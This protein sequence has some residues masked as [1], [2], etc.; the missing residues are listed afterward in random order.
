M[1]D[2]RTLRDLLPGAIC[3]A[4]AL[5]VVVPAGSD[6]F[7][8]TPRAAPMR[9][10]AS[11]TDP[12]TIL[13]SRAGLAS[14]PPPAATTDEKVVQVQMIGRKHVPLLRIV[15]HIRTR[16]GQP[17]DMELIEEDVRRLN[18][19]GLF[20]SV[21]T[22]TQRAAGG[23]IVIFEVVERPVLQY[24]KYVGNELVR[25]SVLAD[26]AGIKPGDAM[27]PFAVEEGRSKIETYYR[28][29]GF[30]NVRVTV[31]EG[32]EVDDQGAIYLINEGKKQRILWTR[33]VGNS[34]HI[35]TDARLRTQ[36]QSKP[37]FLWI[38]K[39]E[40]DRKEIEED[41]HRLKAYYASLGFLDARIG[42]DP[43]FDRDKSWLTL[44]FVIHE[45]P[46]YKI[47][48]V[49]FVGNERFADVE[50]AETTE[51]D[52]GMY[53][54]QTELQSD[55]TAIQ[56]K[57]GALGYVF[58]D[59]RPDTRYLGQDQPGM[60]DLVYE[61]REGDRY[62]VGRI[63]V[64]IRGQ[65][66]T[67]H[68][69]IRT[70]LDRLSLAPGDIVD[71]RE[72]RAS[73]RRLRA[74][75]LFLHEPHRGVEP[76]IVFSP[77]ELSEEETEIARRPGGPSRGR[78]PLTRGQSPDRASRDRTLVLTVN[79]DWSA[80]ADEIV[81][82]ERRDPR[83]WTRAAPDAWG[84]PGPRRGTETRNN[85]PRAADEGSTSP[86]ASRHESWRPLP[87]PVATP[88]EAEP[89]RHARLCPVAY[90]R[91]PAKRPRTTLV[92]AQSPDPG[93][94]VPNYAQGKPLPGIDSHLA[95]PRASMFPQPPA[96]VQGGT[97]VYG[98]P[99]ASA[100]PYG[101]PQINPAQPGEAPGM[102]TASEGPAFTPGVPPPQPGTPGQ[103][104]PFYAP[105]REDASV[106][107][108]L[109]PGGGILGGGDGVFSGQPPSAD[110]VDEA[111]R[112]LPL[113]AIAEESR[114][115][116]IMLGVGVTSDAGLV[117]SVVVDEQNFDLFRFPRSFEEIRNGKAWRG[118][119]QRFRAEAVP[120][121][122]VQRY[123]VSFTEPYLYVPFYGPTQVSLGLSGYFFNRIYLDWAEERLGG[124]VRTGYQFRPDL[125][126]NFTFRGEKVAIYNPSVD[127]GLVPELDEVLGDN[128]LFGFR[129]GIAHD[130]RDSA[131]LP[132]E[133][134]LIEFGFEQVIGSFEYPRGDID[135]RKYF[136]LRQRADGSGRHVLSVGASFGITGDDTPI[137]D[138]YFIGGFSTLRGFDFRGASPRSPT[139]VIVGGH[140]QLLG[141]I[142]YLFPITADDT[143]RGVVFCDAGTVETGYDISD[144][145]FRVAPGFGLRVTIPAM[146]PAPLA[147]D[148]AWP[149][150]KAD[151]DR[152][153]V[154][155]FFIGLR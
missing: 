74:S 66:V 14:P 72:L 48:D 130:T 89:A 37:G 38:I 129:V 34:P 68:T 53:F 133:G 105:P 75:G 30:S 84:M 65:D 12:A 10:P 56:E 63:D 28:S 128:E 8:Q 102:A 60:V 26:K 112:S 70:V 127:P 32:N 3:L 64:E 139:G 148:F 152:T 4:A 57:Y 106:W 113:Q 94:A 118:A 22:M 67:P 88:A 123:M 79:G 54:N 50:L 13:S 149:V 132:T 92:R 24:V 76:K 147:F 17:L 101:Q 103:P 138:H 81:G 55:V 86:R 150:A 44:T 25:K 82:R 134:H 18:R 99:S 154:F 58:A 16:A 109:M 98:T 115:G 78:R 125:T 85:P 42:C 145:N 111:L 131:F 136:T 52:S 108:R 1:A 126:A 114:T 104:G 35:A 142:Q 19:S 21:K 69:K 137:Y 9:P 11:A 15:P 5:A 146:G 135:V 29:H 61:I 62:R 71:I 51:L 90:D 153:E 119:G 124:T 45:G 100:S 121:T 80:E 144:E 6:S 143:L 140:T 40:V 43:H 47:R 91:P 33:F 96:A 77:P 97:S 110:P 20:V 95:T 141:S 122:E 93:R 73:E 120:G 39:G 41:K 36:I 27:D 87:L 59:I 83:A 151:T 155:S 107:D 2:D 117:G 49:R 31:I 7:G 116:R 46:R 23:R